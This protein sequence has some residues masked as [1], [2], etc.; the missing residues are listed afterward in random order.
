V[1]R[2]V[3][4]FVAALAEGERRL[5]PAAAHYLTRVHRLGAGD[6]FVAFD[7]EAQLEAAA[8]LT[9]VGAR[10]ASARLGSPRRAPSGALPITLLQGL[11]K[12][13]KLDDVIRDATA[14][15]VER[16]IV[17]TTARSVPQP[18]PEAARARRWRTIA[19]EAARQSGRG[20]LP[21]IEGPIAFAQALGS[22]PAGLRL[23]LD[24]SA[25]VGLAGALAALTA[26]PARS[27]SVLIG[28]EGGLTAEELDAAEHAGF[29]RVA[30]GR[31]TLRT[32]TAAVAV[33]GALV[34]WLSA[35]P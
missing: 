11:S 33:L 30:L 35:P 26:A 14:L 3:R 8:V 24:P 12:A 34:A 32:E 10:Q 25:G 4:V 13:S 22:V 23:C 6:A 18:K 7:P 16:L 20:D 29:T 5:E 19:T 31:L 1:S 21:R 15:G 28:P 17:T 2:Q 9:D 27:V